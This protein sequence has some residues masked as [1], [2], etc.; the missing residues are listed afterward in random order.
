MYI[1]D[2]SRQKFLH[3]KAIVEMYD[4]DKKIVVLIE[5]ATDPVNIQVPNRKYFSN[6]GNF[7]LMVMLY[8][9]TQL[10]RMGRCNMNHLAIGSLCCKVI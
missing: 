5:W 2:R 8:L 4:W 7:K 6:F 10:M 1:M 9:N 3:T